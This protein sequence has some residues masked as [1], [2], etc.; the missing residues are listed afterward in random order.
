MADVLRRLASLGR[1]LTAGSPPRPGPLPHRPQSRPRVLVIGV[2]VSGKENLSR[3]IVETLGLS[4]ACE[5]TQRWLSIGPVSTDPLVAR[6]TL[7]SIETPTPKFTLLNRHV[8]PEE[9]EAHDYFM[10]CDDDVFLPPDFVDRF[11][12]WQ[13][14]CGFALAQPARTWNS[15]TDHSFVRRRWLRARRTRFVE[16]GP[17]FC[18]AR[19]MAKLMFPFDLSSPMG[20]GYDLVWPVLAE[21]NAMT[22]GIVDDVAIEH[23]IRPRGAL[24]KA[25][26]EIE[27]MRRLLHAN[28]HLSAREAFVCLERYR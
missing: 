13:Q 7:A 20:W 26:A 18:A 27:S 2:Y 14:H 9:L 23:S 11:I 21:R 22:L 25:S 17:V 8:R 15:F 19:P 6:H 1:R 16:I 24:Y 10:V 4:D 3:H 5:V 12:G 28:E